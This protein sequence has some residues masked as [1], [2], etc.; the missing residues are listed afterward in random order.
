MRI[1]LEDFCKFWVMAD[2]ELIGPF[3]TQNTAQAWIDDR[4][5]HGYNVLDWHIVRLK[6]NIMKKTTYTVSF[7]NTTQTLTGEQLINFVKVAVV[8]NKDIS[9][10]TINRIN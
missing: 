2:G 4:D 7:G 6:C 9:N 1:P 3:D 5:D 8:N 10:F